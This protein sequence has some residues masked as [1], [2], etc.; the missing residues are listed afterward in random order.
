[1]EIILEDTLQKYYEEVKEYEIYR[2]INPNCKNCN[3]CYEIYGDFECRIHGCLK[4]DG[5]AC[6]DWK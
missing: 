6:E 2:K 1:M 3:N 5:K 4:W